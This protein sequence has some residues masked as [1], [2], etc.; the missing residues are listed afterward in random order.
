MVALR[1]ETL[2]DDSRLKDY[3]TEIPNIIDDFGLTPYGHRLYSHYKRAAG[4]GKCTQGAR[5]IARICGMSLGTTSN[6][7]RELAQAGLIWIDPVQNDADEVTLPDLWEH[8]FKVYFERDRDKRAEIF[9]GI[10]RSLREHPKAVA[11]LAVMRSRGEQMRSRGEHPRSSGEQKKEPSKNKPIE[12]ANTLSDDAFAS[13][14]TRDPLGD[15]IDNVPNAPAIAEAKQKQAAQ[16]LA[17]PTTDDLTHFLQEK[18]LEETPSKVPQKVSP[19]PDPPA[20][21]SW[22]ASD[23]N[24][25]RCHLLKGETSRPLCKIKPFNYPQDNATK[26]EYPPCEDCLAIADKPK[27]PQR[28]PSSDLI[29]AMHNAIPD[30]IRPPGKPHYGKQ[31][32]PADVLHA[33]G[34]T[35]ERIKAYVEWAYKNDEWIKHGS[36]GQPII[37]TMYKVQERIKAYEASLNGGLSNGSTAFSRTA[38][39]SAAGGIGA[40]GTT[41]SAREQASGQGRSEASGQTVSKPGP[42]ARRSGSV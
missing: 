6:A 38:D 1:Q 17:E 8:N 29:D 22:Y 9:E 18:A 40:S 7:K 20:G 5:T 37:M 4:N 27:G 10:K 13:P 33:A 28:K 30:A 24:K 3:R 31:S 41:E 32:G 34:Y 11:S 15:E 14:T 26:L 42:F 25:G 35:P 12:E 36:T 23:Y 16:K 2:K 39:Q 21:Y 19:L